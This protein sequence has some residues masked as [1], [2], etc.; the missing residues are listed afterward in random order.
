MNIK[1]NSKAGFS[2]IEVVL[3]LAIAGLI[4]LMV[5][6]ALPA[7]QRNQRDIQRRNDAGSFISQITSYSTNNNGKVP[8]TAAALTTF[9]TN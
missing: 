5:F 7:V 6:I 9:Q 4:F 1:P 3:V 2:I 8:A